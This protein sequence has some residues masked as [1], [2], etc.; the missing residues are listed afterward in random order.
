[1]L[2]R[3]S[4]N[5]EQRAQTF[6]EYSMV[7]GVIMLTLI[8]MRPMLIRGGQSMVKVMTDQ[9]GNQQAAEQDF[10][11]GYMKKQISRGNAFSQK[12]KKERRGTYGYEYNE[13]TITNT[14]MVTNMG[15]K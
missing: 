8:A 14:E 6:V 1:M 9:V 13:S 2:K 15:V 10:S 3:N 4:H 7:I 11:Q 5:N 12:F